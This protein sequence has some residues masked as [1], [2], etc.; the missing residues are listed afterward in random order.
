M[1]SGATM[2]RLAR[3]HAIGRGARVW[4]GRRAG[5]YLTIGELLEIYTRDGFNHMGTAMRRHLDTWMATDRAVVEGPVLDRTS[6]VWFPAPEDMATAVKVASERCG[7]LYVLEIDRNEWPVLRRMHGIQ[8]E[9]AEASRC[10]R[11]GTA[12]RTYSTRGAPGPR[13]RSRRHT[14]GASRRRT[15]CAR[16]CGGCTA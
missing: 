6:A 10:T 13:G 9:I 16:W 14:T 8:T 3:A 1:K 4:N 5:C 2:Y 15:R 11:Y 7:G 12:Y